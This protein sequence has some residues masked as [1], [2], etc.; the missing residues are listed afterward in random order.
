MAKSGDAVQPV[1]ASRVP[2]GDLSFASFKVELPSLKEGGAQ[3][4]AGTPRV[5]P[6]GGPGGVTG[7]KKK[8]SRKVV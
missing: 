2:G 7:V 3:K 6:W 1:A 4:T 8:I 5:D